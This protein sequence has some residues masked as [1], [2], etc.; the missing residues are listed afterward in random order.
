[1]IYKPFGNTGI[2]ISQLGFGCMRLPGAHVDGKFQPDQEKVDQMLMRAYEL[3]QKTG[4]R[5]MRTLHKRHMASRLCMKT[6]RQHVC[7]DGSDQ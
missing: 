4:L 2:Q 7:S 5:G 1:M 3:G 6:E